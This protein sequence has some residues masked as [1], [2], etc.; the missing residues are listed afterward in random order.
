MT[1]GCQSLSLIGLKDT[2]ETVEKPPNHNF[3][4]CK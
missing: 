1:Q 2:S 3:E 4:A